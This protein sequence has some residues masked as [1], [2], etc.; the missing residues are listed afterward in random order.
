MENKIILINRVFIGL[1]VFRIVGLNSLEI[2][3]R[4]SFTRNY[5]EQ[6]HRLME[7]YYCRP[8]TLPILK[9]V[10]RTFTTFNG[11]GKSAKR[12]QGSSGPVT[13]TKQ[14]T[15]HAGI[16]WEDSTSPINP[17]SF[18]LLS[19]TTTKREGEYRCKLVITL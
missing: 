15:T 2:I 5:C 17:G 4:N 7:S 1:L 8:C 9:G 12:D 3:T 13:V 11:K 16:L 18:I 10:T 19:A 6:T 14:N